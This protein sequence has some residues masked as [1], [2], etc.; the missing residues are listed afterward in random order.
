MLKKSCQWRLGMSLAVETGNE[1]GSGD[2]E[3]GWQ[4]RLGMRLAVET[5][6]E[7]G[8]GDWE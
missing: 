3:R 7:S 2:W 4:W 1:A 5:G 6:N 8:S